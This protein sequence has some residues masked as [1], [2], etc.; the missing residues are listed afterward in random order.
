MTTFPELPISAEWRAVRPGEAEPLTSADGVR[1]QRAIESQGDGFRIRVRFVNGSGGP[2]RL[3]T[4]SPAVIE[5]ESEWFADGLAGWAVWLQ[6]WSMASDTFTYRF[7]QGDP[8]YTI[9]GGFSF[10][11]EQPAVMSA[12]GTTE[13]PSTLRVRSCGMMLL[14]HAESGRSLVIGFVTTA[15]QF[16][17]IELLCSANERELLRIEALCRTDGQIIEDGAT[18]ESESVVLLAG[19]DPVALTEEYARILGHTMRARVAERV[20]SGWSSPRSSRN[21]VTERDI[22]RTLMDLQTGDLQVEH[23]QIGDGYQTAIGDWLQPN[24]R[25]PRGM[26]F[27]ADRIRD[28]GLRPGLWL[29]PLAL[30]RDSHALAEHPEFVVRNELGE[31]IWSDGSLGC[32]ATL[33]CSH[34]GARA[35]L[36]EMIGDV[37][38]DWGFSLLKLDA[39]DFNTAAGA[40]YHAVNTTSVMNLRAGLEVIRAAAGDRT[41]LVGANCPFA[42]AVGLLD[43]MGV[44][45]EVTPRWRDGP[46]TTV[47]EALSLALPRGWMHGRLWLNY[48]GGLTLRKT[49][50][51][52]LNEDEARFLATGVALSG[53]LAVLSDDLATL[54]PSR[55]AIIRRVLPAAGVAAR[56]LDLFQPEAPAMWHLPRVN[57]GVIAFLNWGDEA[58][59]VSVDLTPLGL[60]GVTRAVERWSETARLLTGPIYSERRIAPRSARVVRFVRDGSAPEPGSHILA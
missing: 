44:G 30:Q 56:P 19:I 13:T 25:F 43:A 50:D 17:E 18:F 3:E 47:Q 20:P 4:L 1:V 14:H 37:V 46:L 58:T 45:P 26:R 54:A 12:D 9:H 7:G 57:G 60:A 2:V 6:G 28:A 23:L 41:F 55:A 22:L 5:G 59:D 49:G 48:P 39:L 34:P 29:A 42:P 11:D 51:S 32:C 33:D 21:P 15:R 53:G 38:R 27:L 24:E 36:A 16:G 40:R 35:W 52:M 8:R 31:V 10:I